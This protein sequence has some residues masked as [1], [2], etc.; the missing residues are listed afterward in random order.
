M[1]DPFSFFRRNYFDFELSGFSEEQM[2]TLVRRSR[3]SVHLFDLIAQKITEE[4]EAERFLEKTASHA[5]RVGF[6]LERFPRS[7][8]VFTLRD[9]RDGLLSA[10]RNPT[11]W[12][13]LDSSAPRRS[14]A[15]N[16]RECARKDLEHQTHERVTL[17]RYEELCEE[18]EPL[19]RSTMQFLGETFEKSQLHPT[20]YSATDVSN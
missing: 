5:L 14:Y 7:K 1:T 13:S 3:D 11:Y 16:L 17:V 19:I 2:K 6:L 15:E 9:V 4:S 18:P 10:R 20:S 8:I 12:S